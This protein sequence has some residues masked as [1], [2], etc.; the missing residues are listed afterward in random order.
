MVRAA[1]DAPPACLPS[2]TLLL[3][4]PPAGLTG[5]P[6]VRFLLA[7]L[8]QPLV[9]QGSLLP[10]GTRST[11]RSSTASGRSARADEVGD[12]RFA[13]AQGNPLRTAAS[14]AQ[15]TS[16]GGGS[17]TKSSGKQERCWR[18]TMLLLPFQL[19]SVESLGSAVRDSCS[20]GARVAARAQ[21]AGELRV[22]T[23]PLGVVSSCRGEGTGTSERATP[24]RY[25]DEAKRVWIALAQV[26]R[27]RRPSVCGRPRITRARIGP[28]RA[29][30]S[31]VQVDGKLAER[32]GPS[33][34]SRPRHSGRWSWESST[35]GVER[36]S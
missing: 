16:G 33:R 23:D 31:L 34:G 11:R 8:T 7:S 24:R 12:G 29:S 21:A 32:P 26:L 1:V 15:R 9:R 25:C 18:H 19:G 5:L 30:T 35:S 6:P 3:Q 20:A 22:T 10:P 27:S 4:I 17:Q 13:R 28:P 36:A 2:G 14:C